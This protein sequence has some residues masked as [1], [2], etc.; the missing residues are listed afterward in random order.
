MLTQ[1]E[2]R[3]HQATVRYLMKKKSHTLQETQDLNVAVMSIQ[4][5]AISRL[6]SRVES[7]EAEVQRLK[8][9]G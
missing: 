2:L 8:V 4:G 9:F 1:D 3:E 6:T 5:D 7:L